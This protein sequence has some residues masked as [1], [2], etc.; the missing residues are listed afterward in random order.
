MVKQRK[1][2]ISALDAIKSMPFKDY[3]QEAKKVTID[4]LHN[5]LKMDITKI[6]KTLGMGRTNIYR[7]INA[8]DIQEGTQ[9]STFRTA[10][11][12]M[13]EHKRSNLYARVLSH[14]ENKLPEAKFN[15]ATGLAKVLQDADR[16]DKKVNIQSDKTMVFQIV[17]DSK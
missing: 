12:R 3:P 9:W 2:D 1:V 16:E 8:E 13:F 17:K 5:D 4:V 7:I 10:I 11:K 6:G 15:E 14:L